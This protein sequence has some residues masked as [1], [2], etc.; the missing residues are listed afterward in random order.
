MDN[1]AATT[2]GLRSCDADLKVSVGRTSTITS[3]NM[4]DNMIDTMNER[5]NNS[6]K[7]VCFMYPKAILANAS[8]YVDTMLSIPMKEK[9]TC[10]ISFSDIRPERWLKWTNFVLDPVCMFSFSLFVLLVY[11][12]ILF[13]RLT[14]SLWCVCFILCF[15]CV[16]LLGACKM[17]PFDE[18]VIDMFLFYDKYQFRSGIHLF[19]YK[20]SLAITS[21]DDI[22]Q[23]DHICRKVIFDMVAMI[24]NDTAVDLPLTKDV[25]QIFIT[26]QFILEFLDFSKLSGDEIRTF[27]PYVFKDYNRSLMTHLDEMADIVDGAKI[28]ERSVEDLKLIFFD[29]SFASTLK[30]KLLGNKQLEYV[31]KNLTVDQIFIMV[32]GRVRIIR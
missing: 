14:F 9:D 4:I 8:E 26:R 29:P 22:G 2:K 25:L 21:T 11:K 1:F 12:M 32:R 13:L 18:D 3:D 28:N 16:P 6:N 30:T 31:L 17:D 7:V 20:L 15:H 24:S 19:D 5:S 27:L 10:T 23:V